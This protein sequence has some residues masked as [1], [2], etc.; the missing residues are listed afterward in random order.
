MNLYEKSL[1]M[2]NKDKYV[3]MLVLSNT[4]PQSSPYPCPEVRMVMANFPIDPEIKE[5]FFYGV[6]TTGIKCKDAAHR[7]Y[8]RPATIGK[9]NPLTLYFTELLQAE[10]YMK[11]K[12]GENW[13]DKY[14]IVYVQNSSK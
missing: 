10:D 6:L 5:N 9:I 14:S 11:L 7:V 2:C 3:Y 12:Y 1:K 4:L 8:S 13:M